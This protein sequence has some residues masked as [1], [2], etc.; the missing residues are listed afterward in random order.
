MDPRCLHPKFFFFWAILV[1]LVVPTDAGSLLEGVCDSM[2]NGEK[3]GKSA[4]S[5]WTL[6][7]FLLLFPYFTCVGRVHVCFFVYV[8]TCECVYTCVVT[9]WKPEVDIRN[10]P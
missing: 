8:G 6:S 4:R 3:A 2:S 5:L 7:P 9:V 1:W 10:H